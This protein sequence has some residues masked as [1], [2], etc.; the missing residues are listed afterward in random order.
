MRGPV[1]QGPIALGGIL[2]GKGR[3]EGA[4]IKDPQ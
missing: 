4:V 1:R 3:V 2:G